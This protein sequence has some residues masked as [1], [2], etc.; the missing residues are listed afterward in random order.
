MEATR[1]LPTVSDDGLFKAKKSGNKR[2]KKLWWFRRVQPVKRGR[3]KYR[4]GKI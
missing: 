2:E 3:G 4:R 1:I